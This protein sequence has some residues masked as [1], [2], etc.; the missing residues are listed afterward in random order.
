M[1]LYIKD[2]KPSTRK[3]LHLINSFSKVPGHKIS[4]QNPVAFLHRNDKQ[5]LK[6]IREI[7]PFTIASKRRGGKEINISPGNF[8]QK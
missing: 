5:T 7:M 3:L 8:N 6:E 2:H 1:I 4:S